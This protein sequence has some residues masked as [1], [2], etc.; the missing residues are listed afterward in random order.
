MFFQGQVK[1]REFYTWSGEFGVRE[2]SGNFIVRL[3]Q[4]SI[5]IYIFNVTSYFLFKLPQTRSEKFSCW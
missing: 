2:K 4:A 5:C 1:V 3:I